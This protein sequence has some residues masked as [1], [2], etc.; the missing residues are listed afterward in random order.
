MFNL[1]TLPVLTV[2]RVTEKA[3]GRPLWLSTLIEEDGSEAI[4]HD[5]HSFTDAIAAA[6]VWREDGVPTL[7]L[8]VEH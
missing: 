8:G 2:E 6:R 5:T 3:T 4:V 7:W 1:P